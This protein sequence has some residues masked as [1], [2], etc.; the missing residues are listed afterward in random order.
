[1][2]LSKTFDLGRSSFLGE[3]IAI[4]RSN[5]S[6]GAGM[7]SGMD[8]DSENDS[9]SKYQDVSIDNEEDSGEIC[10]GVAK[11]PTLKLSST[12]ASEDSRSTFYQDS[13]MAPAIPTKKEFE[14]KKIS[15]NSGPETFRFLF[16]SKSIPKDNRSCEDACFNTER[17]L[18]VA[19]G[20]SGWAK[21]GISSNEFSSQLIKYCASEIK[22]D[23]RKDEEKAQIDLG[24]VLSKAYEK[25]TAVGSSTVSMVAINDNTMVGLNLGDSGF[26]CFSKIEGI[27][28][29]NGV[30]KEQQHDFNTP[31]QLSRLP[32]EQ[33]TVGINEEDLLELK[34]IIAQNRLCADPPC[35]ADKYTL[36]IHEDDIVILGTDG[37]FYYVQKAERIV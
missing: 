5:Q 4:S 31:F 10:M 20:V 7:G 11:L 17:A 8:V 27:Y 37:I 13:K 1:M 19:D 12:I 2:E 28:V 33:D 23:L 21:Y 18:G 34:E 22:Q 24:N 14:E 36:P 30:S 6:F 25:I 9:M 3:E 29:N 26:V 15:A 32:T 35:A 16:G